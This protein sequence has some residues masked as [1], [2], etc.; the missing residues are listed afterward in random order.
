VIQGVVGD[1]GSLVAA[2]HR[3]Y[4]QIVLAQ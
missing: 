4:C 2:D 3:A 1:A